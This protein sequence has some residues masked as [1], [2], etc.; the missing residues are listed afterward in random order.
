VDDG[1]VSHPVTPSRQFDGL[2]SDD[3]MTRSG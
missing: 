1:T 3:P 2:P